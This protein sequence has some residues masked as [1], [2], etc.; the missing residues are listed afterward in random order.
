M[1]HHVIA[2]IIAKLVIPGI[3]LFALYV[4]WINCSV[5]EHF[6]ER[7]RRTVGAGYSENLLKFLFV[8]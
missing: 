6:A 3:M 8:R 7:I 1:T 2:R 5:V 4:L